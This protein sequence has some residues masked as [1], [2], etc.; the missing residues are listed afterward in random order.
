M[1]EAHNNNLYA[2]PAELARFQ[3]LAFLIGIV[4][5]VAAAIAALLIPIPG[6]RKQFFHSYL[7]AYVFWIGIALGSLAIVMVQHVAGGA[8]GVVIRRILESSTR[9]LPLMAI[10]FL[11]I[12]LGMH[13]LY[14]WS[15]R[16]A[17]GENEILRL[18]SGYFNVGFFIVR[19]V[20]YF[21]I[22]GTLIYFLNKW[23][24]E[25]DQTADIRLANRMQ[26]LSG[27]GIVLFAL[28][29]TFAAVDWVMSL[30]PEWYSTIFG[31]LFMGGWGL[32]ALSFT[33]AVAVLLAN[34]EPLRGVLA[35]RHFHD[36]GKLLLAFVMLWAY[37]NLSQ[38]LII[39]WGNLP[40]EVPWYLRRMTGDGK[41]LALR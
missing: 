29:V 18:Q 16:E 41:S 30:D 21:A 20:I 38:F 33:I 35:P 12:L 4:L 19:A 26:T 6:L 11:P 36:L 34:R 40:E 17:V 27:P 37:F 15:H 25:Q 10:L 8:W 28:T 9:T 1:I 24:A 5:L 13:D 31:I 22:W 7:L 3:R 23:S 2:P 14:H 39:W 32:S